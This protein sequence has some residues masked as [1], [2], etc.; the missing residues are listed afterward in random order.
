[1]HSHRAAILIVVRYIVRLGYVKLDSIG[2]WGRG[3]QTH[4]RIW[5]NLTFKPR[6]LH[7]RCNIW[8]IFS[9]GLWLFS[10]SSLTR[11]HR[12][13]KGI[14]IYILIPSLKVVLLHNPV[15]AHVHTFLT[16]MSLVTIRGTTNYCH[17]TP[18]GWRCFVGTSYILH[19]LMPRTKCMLLKTRDATLF[20]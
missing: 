4:H 15:N 7:A 16:T 14:Y 2:D 11:L 10:N 5:P 18:T 3:T 19:G 17:K 13:R 6:S 1:M 8:S 9:G 20:P 12:S